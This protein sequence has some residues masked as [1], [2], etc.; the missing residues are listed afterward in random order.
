MNALKKKIGQIVEMCEEVPEIYRVKCFGVILQK[1]LEDLHLGSEPIRPAKVETS[2]GDESEDNDIG[3]KLFFEDHEINIK[4]V[5]K[6]LHNKNG[7]WQIIVKNT[8]K[9]NKADAQIALALLMGI[10]N[11][12]SEGKAEV[13]KGELVDICKRYSNLILLILEVL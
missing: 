10:A 8:G 9:T 7:K 6:I 4:Q 11:L 2:I 1:Y 5:N 12:L 3:K 13:L